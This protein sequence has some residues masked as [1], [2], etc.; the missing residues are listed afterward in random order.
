[1][2]LACELLK[3]ELACSDKQICSRLHT[4]F[5][6]LY[7]CGINQVQTDQDQSHF[8]LAKILAQFRGRLD[9]QIMAKLLQ[10]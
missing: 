6:V 8:V 3:A 5:A 1:V 10:I 7:A 4:D 2:L 9:E